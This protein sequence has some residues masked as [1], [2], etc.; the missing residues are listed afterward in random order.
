MEASHFGEIEKVGINVEYSRKKSRFLWIWRDKIRTP[1]RVDEIMGEWG[2]NKDSET[3]RFPRHSPWSLAN[4]P[5]ILEYLQWRMERKIEREKKRSKLRR[6]K[7]RCACHLNRP[8]N[9]HWKAKPTQCRHSCRQK[10]KKK[11]QNLDFWETSI[12]LPRSPPNMKL[13]GREEEKLIER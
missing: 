7:N 11:I 9:I 4:C 1:K 6:A 8:T 12:Y 3:H 2:Q 5:D 10:K 13:R